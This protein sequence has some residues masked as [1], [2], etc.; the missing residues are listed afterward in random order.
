[1]R[2]CEG[3]EAVIGVEERIDARFMHELSLLLLVGADLHTHG[4]IE[5]QEAIPLRP[6]FVSEHQQHS[7]R[8]APT[9]NRVR[10]SRRDVHQA[11]DP[12]TRQQRVWPGPLT[13]KGGLRSCLR[14]IKE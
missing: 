8:N 3:L 11:S 2:S 12:V 7:F 5:K 9:L 13:R 14:K 1:M 6:R 4:K 10:S